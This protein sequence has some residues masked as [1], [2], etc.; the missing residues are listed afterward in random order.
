[1]LKVPCKNC[2]FRHTGC[3]ATCEKYKE[4]QEKNEALREIKN[5]ESALNMDYIAFRKS[6]WRK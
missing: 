5:K 2:P 4:F 6:G 3:H 1:L